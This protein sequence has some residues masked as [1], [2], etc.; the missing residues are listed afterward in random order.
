MVLERILS[1]GENDMKKEWWP[2]LIESYIYDI[3]FYTSLTIYRIEKSI[4]TSRTK[5]KQ[6]SLLE[7]ARVFFVS[8]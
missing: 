8:F 3:F 4:S 1:W 2:G 6:G 7:S 5:T